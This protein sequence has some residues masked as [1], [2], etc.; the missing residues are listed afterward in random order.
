MRRL[1]V[2]ALIGLAACGGGKPHNAATTSQG[3]MVGAWQRL[4][5]EQRDGICQAVKDN[6]IDTFM[7]GIEVEDKKAGGE[8]V[9]AACDLP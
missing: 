5:P 4:T 7:A 6:G 3:Q 2:V 1:L 9:M 8:I